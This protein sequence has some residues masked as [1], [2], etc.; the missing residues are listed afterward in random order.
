VRASGI[1]TTLTNSDSLCTFAPF[2]GVD[3]TLVTNDPKDAACNSI[4][5]TWKLQ[6]WD[7]DQL[8]PISP[9]TPGSCLDHTKLSIRFDRGN[10]WG[11]C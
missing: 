4:G 8:C 6:H 1:T 5:R 10:C 11:S 2:V 3:T 9:G 7:P